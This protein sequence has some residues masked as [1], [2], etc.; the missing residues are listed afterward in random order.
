MAGSHFEW[1]KQASSYSQ[2][3][4]AIYHIHNGMHHLFATHT[5]E[6]LVVEY[7]M[8]IYNNQTESIQPDTTIFHSVSADETLQGTSW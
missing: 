7:G 5:M 4:A 8:L 3:L 1:Q 6:E 2:L